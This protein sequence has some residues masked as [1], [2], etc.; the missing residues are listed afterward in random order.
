MSGLTRGQ[1]LVRLLFRVVG[2]A[3]V[4]LPPYATDEERERF[5]R[6]RDRGP[7]PASDAPPLPGYRLVTYTDPSGIVHRSAVPLTEPPD[8]P[9]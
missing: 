4:G 9:T 7:A 3:Q 1:R 2:P 8:N 6:D 5:E